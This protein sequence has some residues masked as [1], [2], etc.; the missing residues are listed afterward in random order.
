MPDLN[1]DALLD[2]C[3][4]TFAEAE[5]SLAGL[6]SPA[7]GAPVHLKRDKRA[8]N[9]SASVPS[10]AGIK[11]AEIKERERGI[12]GL[13]FNAL[14]ARLTFEPNKNL[15][16]SKQQ[17]IAKMNEAIHDEYEARKKASLIGRGP[18]NPNKVLERAPPDPKAWKRTQE[19]TAMSIMNYV[20]MREQKHYE[21]SLTD[22][23]ES[24]DVESLLK[25]R[26]MLR[27]QTIA[28]KNGKP[29]IRAHS[30][31]A[32]SLA[33]SFLPDFD[34]SDYDG[35]K[36]AQ[37]RALESNNEEIDPFPYSTPERL[38]EL[39]LESIEKYK[40]MRERFA[41]EWE[42]KRLLNEGDAIQMM[43]VRNEL[44]RRTHKELPKDPEF[45]WSSRDRI[46]ELKKESIAK[47]MQMRT[48]YAEKEELKRQLGDGDAKQLI[49][50]RRKIR[51][52][53]E[54][55]MAERGL[56]DKFP[57]PPTGLVTERTKNLTRESV[58]LYVDRRKEGRAKE[59]AENEKTMAKVRS[60]MAESQRGDARSVEH[61]IVGS[62]AHADIETPGNVLTLVTNPVD[63]DP[64]QPPPGTDTVKAV[65][66]P[67]ETLPSD[68]MMRTSK[69]V[70][71]IA[72][73][74]SASAPNSATSDAFATTAGSRDGS[75]ASLQKDSN[76]VT[77]TAT[78]RILVTTEWPIYHLLE[79]TEIMV[80][81]EVND[82]PHFSNWH[83]TEKY[84]QTF[85]AA[86]DLLE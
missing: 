49:I 74:K 60:K 46:E 75:L 17:F 72:L 86:R 7:R 48:N 40:D 73:D 43:E 29:F 70:G 84:M 68:T 79:P 12:A 8:A 76:V 35:P 1:L 11:G 13:S 39:H 52:K 38:H 42:L 78:K 34:P 28:K 50:T 85:E 24:G 47:Y 82:Q 55:S 14:K 25:V 22:K 26:S 64:I 69:S 65:W 3:K 62:E 45:P 18:E 23:M 6:T 2:D 21:K 54:Q 71:G 32:I 57:P 10:L 36:G 19:L 41:K 33:Q 61:F 81:F 58:E 80:T 44:R 5:S 51:Q 20:N 67:A 77:S 4:R 31:Q 15:I 83:A 59:A 63:I 37:R 56:S 30:D 66:T 53:I 9:L 27:K 16:K